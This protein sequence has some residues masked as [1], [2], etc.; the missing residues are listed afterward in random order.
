M[1]AAT[2]TT[3]RPRSFATG[4]LIY[5]FEASLGEMYP[6]GLFPE[7]IRFHNQFAGTVTDGPFAG[8]RIF[9]LDPFLL[10]PDG[11]GVI[12]APEVIEAGETRVSVQVRG[13]VVPPEGLEMPPL[14]ALLAPGFAFPDI[15]FRVTGA[16]VIRTSAPEFE[17]LNR[18]V[19]VIE[20]TVSLATGVLSVEARA[21]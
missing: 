14:D 20:G 3:N 12:D 17:A 13:Y 11:I 5:R 9:G 8:A 4:S 6:I 21:A 19:A 10:R 7:G 16:G 18:T 2:D 15:P 1:T